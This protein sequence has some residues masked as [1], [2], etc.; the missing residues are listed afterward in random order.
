MVQSSG[1]RG[2]KASASPGNDGI[3][4]MNGKYV[5]ASLVLRAK[6]AT[7]IWIALA[8]KTTGRQIKKIESSVVIVKLIRTPRYSTTDRTLKTVPKPIKVNSSLAR[9]KRTPAMSLPNTK[10]LR[11]IGL[12]SKGY[13]DC[14]SR[15]KEVVFVIIGAASLKI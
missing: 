10:L 12:I 4:A 6:E 9:E 8:R 5:P 7:S 15:S 3:N 2:K 14:R 13:R 1:F 11:G